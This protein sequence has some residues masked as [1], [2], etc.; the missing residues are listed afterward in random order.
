M[1]ES[2]TVQ[3]FLAKRDFQGAITLLEILPDIPDSERKNRLAMHVLNVLGEEEEASIYAAKLINIPE[4]RLSIAALEYFKGNYR[5][6]S[7]MYRN[8]SLH[9]GGVSAMDI[10]CAMSY[11]HLDSNDMAIELCEKYLKKHPDS[12][13]ASNLKACCHYRL[14]NIKGAVDAISKVKDFEYQLPE[15]FRDIINHNVAVL[16]DGDG[17]LQVW[18]QCKNNV[19]EAR[20]N[21]T[22]YFLRNNNIRSSLELLKEIEPRTSQEIFIKANTYC[23]IGQED[24]DDEAIEIA[25]S[26]YYSI[27]SN[28]SDCDTITGRQAMASYLILQKKYEEALVY[29]DSIK[30][31]CSEND[32]FNANYGQIKAACGDFNGALEHLLYVTSETARND[33]TYLACLAK[34]YVSTGHPDQAWELNT[35]AK[36]TEEVFALVQLVASSCYKNKYYGI[37][38]RAYHQAT[39]LDPKNTHHWYGLRASIMG[40]LKNITEKGLTDELE[41]QL[42]DS[43]KSLSTLKGME[44]VDQ[45]SRTLGAWAR[46]REIYL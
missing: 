14:G 30:V 1:Q 39:L 17:A 25:E 10:Y 32:E 33:F 44:D 21:L 37:A 5:E 11:Y 38:A 34:C 40:I 6:A 13:L 7:E 23:A 28:E 8:V 43:Y 18:P 36:T 45:F 22:I 20:F 35:S 4:D 29:L 2:P 41:Q 15:A 26:L 19:P 46:N 12:I 31:Y 42:S 27:G 3:E 16:R 24:N 9:F